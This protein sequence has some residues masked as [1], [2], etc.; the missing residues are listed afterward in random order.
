MLTCEACNYV[1]PIHNPNHDGRY[2][3]HHLHTAGHEQPP[4]HPPF[5]GEENEPL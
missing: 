3:E 5:D 1:G 2:F 4:S